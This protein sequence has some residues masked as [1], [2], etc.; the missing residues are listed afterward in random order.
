MISDSLF[1]GEQPQLSKN[2]SSI[3]TTQ[4]VPFGGCDITIL[5][6]DSDGPSLK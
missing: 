1:G 6:S 3:Y 2:F 4:F 5:I